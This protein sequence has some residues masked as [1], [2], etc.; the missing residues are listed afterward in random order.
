[1]LKYKIMADMKV[2]AMILS[3]HGD[4]QTS[5]ARTA[6]NLHGSNYNLYTE[7]GAD[8][9]RLVGRDFPVYR[10]AKLW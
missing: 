2:S 10:V 4:V 3:L 9:A 5:L 8:S 7:S 1:M 6:E